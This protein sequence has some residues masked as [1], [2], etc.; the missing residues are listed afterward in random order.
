[1]NEIGIIAQ[2]CPIV[3][4]HYGK[5]DNKLALTKGEKYFALGLHKLEEMKEDI[6]PLRELAVQA[7]VLARHQEAIDL[8]LRFLEIAPDNAEA[9]LNLGNAFFLTGKIKQALA[10]AKISSRLDPKLKEATFNCSL[11][12]I[13]LGRPASAMKKLQSLIRQIPDYHAARFLFAAATCCRNGIKKGRRAFLKI[14]DGILSKEVLEIAGKEL[15]KTLE[16][17]GRIKDANNIRKAT[18]G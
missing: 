2:P 11:Y 12:E 1:M 4:H 15:A 6:V 17:A 18:P 16:Q 5:L 7:G 10:E 13:H 9:H 8:W 3:I 14:E